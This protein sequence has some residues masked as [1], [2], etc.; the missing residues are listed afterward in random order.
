M[1][2]LLLCLTFAMPL[3]AH[4]EGTPLSGDAFE[5]LTRGKVMNHFQFGGMYGAEEYLPGRRVIWQDGEGCMRG[6]WTE[7]SP[8]LLCFRYDGTAETWCWAYIQRADGGF[9]ALLDG[10]PG[11][12]PITLQ[13]GRGPLSCEENAPSA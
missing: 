10:K 11:D 8:G 12:N 9:D 5:A 3:T 13:P 1:R 4:A 2:A 7:A 6:H